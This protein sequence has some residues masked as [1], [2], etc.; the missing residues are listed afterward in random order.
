M[1]LSK[2]SSCGAKVVDSRGVTDTDN[3]AAPLLY[4]EKTEEIV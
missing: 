2:S 4:N 3:V 1:L